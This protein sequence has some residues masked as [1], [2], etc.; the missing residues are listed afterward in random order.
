[1][2]LYTCTPADTLPSRQCREVSVLNN[3]GAP[4]TLSFGAVVGND[5]GELQD[6]QSVVL[7]VQKNLNEITMSG[8]GAGKVTFVTAI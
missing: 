7:E 1:V 8:S 2:N 5:Y 4:L 3:S 6:G